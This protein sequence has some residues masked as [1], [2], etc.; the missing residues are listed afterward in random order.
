MPNSAVLEHVRNAAIGDGQVRRG[1]ES[2][3]VLLPALVDAAR[4]VVRQLLRSDLP[5]PLPH[6]GHRSR[7][8]RPPSLPAA[9]PTESLARFNPA[10]NWIASSSPVPWS[11]PANQS[12]NRFRCERRHVDSLRTAHATPL[13]SSLDTARLLLA[14][15]TL[16]QQQRRRSHS[17]AHTKEHTHA[18]TQ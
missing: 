13:H 15:V 5:R 18:R 3:P 2:L 9:R 14:S 10:E 6:R 8:L 17:N 12:P 7:G 4:K 16:S 1:L 11:P